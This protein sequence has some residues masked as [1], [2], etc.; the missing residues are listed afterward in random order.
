MTF[1]YFSLTIHYLTKGYYLSFRKYRR[2]NFN[3][4]VFILV[5]LSF[6]LKKSIMIKESL[7]G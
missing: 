3:I 4:Q 7:K 5:K 6:Y 1:H 2:K